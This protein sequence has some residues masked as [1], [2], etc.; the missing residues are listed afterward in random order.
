MITREA[1]ATDLE[2]LWV[3]NE[4]IGTF[5]FEN[6]PEAFTKPSAAD[7]E[8]LQNT[9]RDKSR[10]FLVAEIENRV[11][12]FL[13]AIITKNETI[14]FLVSCPVCRVGTIVVDEKCRA[15]GVGTKLMSAC[16][17]WAASQGAEQI[18]LEVMA[19]N[20]SAQKFYE[21]LGFKDHSHIMCKLID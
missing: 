13:T 16:S 2:A 7:N 9:L 18:R 5:H 1:K 12:G 6:A 19:F 10:L 15:S 3:L 17:K 11:V 8:F 21:K 4:Q 14:P 20:Q